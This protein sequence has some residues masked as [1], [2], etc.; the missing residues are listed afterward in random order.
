M[1]PVAGPVF[2]WPGMSE[3]S[4]APSSSSGLE[5]PQNMAVELDPMVRRGLKKTSEGFPEI[6]EICS[7]DL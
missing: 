5:V 3:T 2:P 7:W 4:G 1:E 6:S